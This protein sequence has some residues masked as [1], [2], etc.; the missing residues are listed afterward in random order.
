MQ[1]R[2]LMNGRGLN[3][4]ATPS[5][6]MENKGMC[7]RLYV[8]YPSH[9]VCSMHYNLE[10]SSLAQRIVATDTQYNNVRPL[11]HQYSKYDET[12]NIIDN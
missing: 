7:I 11:T 10:S 3:H 1:P 12:Y 4:V 6:A 9:I 2:G 8:V 5:S